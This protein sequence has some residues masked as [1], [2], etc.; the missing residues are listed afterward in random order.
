MPVQ[1][2]DQAALRGEPS[3]VWRAGQQRRLNMILSAIPHPETATVLVD[4]CGLGQYVDKLRP[5]VAVAVGLD[6]ELPRLQDPQAPDGVLVN[7]VAERLPFP[8]G[9]FDIVL[10]NEVLE[11]VQDDAAAAREIIR[12]LKPGGRAVVFVPNRGY[13]VEQHGIFWRGQY[14]FGNMPLVNYL[15]NRWRNRLAPH[16]RVY[17]RREIRALFA[18]PR[19]RIVSHRAIFGGY[20]NI[21]ARLGSVGRLLRNALYFLEA[22]P[23]RWLGLSHLIVIEKHAAPR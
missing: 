18:D 23:F 6:I 4:G 9:Q 11:H 13:P 16:V 14:R 7:G 21:I 10:S 8:A 19:T 2:S 1:P 3:Y 17:T 22:T 5:H 12:V 20:D 15:P